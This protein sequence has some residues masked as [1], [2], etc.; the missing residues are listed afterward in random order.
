MVGG[1]LQSAVP[2]T[3]RAFTVA[4]YD[5]LIETGILRE[6]EQIELIEGVIVEMSPIGSRHVACVNRL[7]MLLVGFLGPR[8][9][10][11]VQNPIQLSD[12]SEPQP[13]LAVLRPRADFY[14]AALA[15]PADVLLLIEVA[16]SSLEYD[17]SVKLPL[18]ARA[19]I[20]EVWVINLAAETLA[21]YTDPAEQMY[22]RVHTLKKGDVLTSAALLDLALPVD[23]LFA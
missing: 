1:I 12:Y 8:A 10:I 17:R 2:L 11:S 19:L 22:Q 21:V 7:N 15:T 14:A 3:R 9:I 5:R 18:Y 16:E 6:D 23:T 20:P 13:D 4:E